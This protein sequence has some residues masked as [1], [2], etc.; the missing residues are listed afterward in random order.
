MPIVN[1]VDWNKQVE[2]NKDA[3]GKCAIDVARRVMELLD[4]VKEFDCNDLICKADK[5]GELTGFL[6]GCVAQIVSKCHSRGE[7]FRKKWN[8]DYGVEGKKD[9][10][11]VVNPA[12]MTVT[13][14]NK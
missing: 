5:Q 12:I 11:G 14:K 6:A 9:K 7:E 2:M 10:G 3:Y 8:K 1:E 13:V 4:K